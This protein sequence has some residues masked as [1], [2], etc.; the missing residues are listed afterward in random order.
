MERMDA[1]D[2]RVPCKY[3]PLCYQKNEAHHKKFKHEKKKSPEIRTSPGRNEAVDVESSS[4]PELETD[5]ATCSPPTK[6]Q[7]VEESE[8]K[9]SELE[10]VGKEDAKRI[11]KNMFLVEMPDEFYAF[12]DVCLTI[13]PKKPLEAFKDCKFSLVGPFE[14][15]AGV[16]KENEH[17]VPYTLT[18]WRYFYDP[19]EVQTLL[20]GDDQ[21]Q[22]HWGYY[23]DDPNEMPSYVVSNAAA[24]DCIL[25]DAGLSL[26]ATVDFLVASSL[27]SADPF[28]KVKIMRLQTA[29]QKKAK[30]EKI[31]MHDK[32]EFFAR[33][34][35]IVCPAFHKGGLVVKCDKKTKVGY[36]KME[37]ETNLKKLLDKVCGAETEER[38]NKEMEALDSLITYANIANDEC[39]FGGPLELGINMFCHGNELFHPQIMGVLVA[40]YQLLG[41]PQY[42][43]ILKAHIKSGRKKGSALSIV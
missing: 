3:G 29:L 13:N 43:E 33:K 1:S 24:E 37:T 28:S 31:N 10:F 18:H 14:V 41:R 9:D 5:A 17:Q 32:S 30:E 11:I 22:L 25:K 36:R 26:F 12:W 23:R 16:L 6:K 20:R 21:K 15:L 19:P 2:D 35:K 4:C 8:K 38:R 42:A 27:K 40:T 34:R 39:D 7:K